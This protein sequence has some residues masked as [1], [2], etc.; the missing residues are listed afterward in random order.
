MRPVLHFDGAPDL[1]SRT[2]ALFSS[3]SRLRVRYAAPDKGHHALRTDAKGHP[4]IRAWQTV[5]RKAA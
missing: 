5:F 3:T 2:K 4:I 1:F